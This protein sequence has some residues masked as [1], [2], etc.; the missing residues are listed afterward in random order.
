MNKIEIVQHFFPSENSAMNDL[1]Y[2]C[3][4]QVRSM[5]P[6]GWTHKLLTNNIELNGCKSI[7]NASTL[8]KAKYL[9]ENPYTFYIEADCFVM[10][11]LSTITLSFKPYA[12]FDYACP[13]AAIYGNG[14]AGIFAK[15]VESFDPGVGCICPYIRKNKDLFDPLP[16]GAIKHFGFSTNKGKNYALETN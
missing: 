12:F 15:M 13:G 10:I 7:P 6:L 2:C 9:A 5:V 14:A 4:N 3:I 11:D 1:Y 8:F 16:F